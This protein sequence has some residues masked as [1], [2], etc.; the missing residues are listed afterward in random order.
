MLILMAFLKELNLCI[1]LELSQ[2]LKVNIISINADKQSSAANIVYQVSGFNFNIIE[3]ISGVINVESSVQ[4]ENFQKYLQNFSLSPIFERFSSKN[5]CQ[6]PLQKLQYNA[7]NTAAIQNPIRFGK[8]RINK[9]QMKLAIT[10]ANNDFFL[11][12]VSANT[13]V[14]NSKNRIKNVKIFDTRI[15]SAVDNQVYL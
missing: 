13:D 11:Q 8:N 5:A 1:I 7:W 14:G 9:A 2:S 3:E 4:K 12:K 10:E 6:V 15:I